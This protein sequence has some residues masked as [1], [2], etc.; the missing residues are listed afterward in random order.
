MA[1]KKV[2]PQAEKFPNDNPL[3]EK[4]GI[5]FMQALFIDNT[6]NND[7]PSILRLWADSDWPGMPDCGKDFKFMLALGHSFQSQPK[8]SEVCWGEQKR[9]FDNAFQL[10]METPSLIYCEG[11]VLLQT[12][13][14]PI[15]DEFG[16]G[17]P[18][19]PVPIPH[20]WCI[21][22]AGKV[23][24]NTLREPGAAYFGVPFERRWFLRP[25]AP[26]AG[27][28]LGELRLLKKIPE[29]AIAKA[30]RKKSGELMQE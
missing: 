13:S 8:P 20:A 30:Y 22:N 28:F 6:G 29:A 10:A 16:I 14:I 1:T 5:P 26:G 17:M 18:D 3:T 21:D 9:C 23:V 24:D 15:P 11:Y 2:R 4:A 25:V 7:L 12:S 19:L 27:G